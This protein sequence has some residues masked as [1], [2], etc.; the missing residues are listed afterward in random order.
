MMFIFEWFIIYTL[1]IFAMA[2]D[3]VIWIPDG[4]EWPEIKKSFYVVILPWF[5][6]KWYEY[7]FPKTK[8]AWSYCWHKR[9][10][11][12]IKHPRDI[13]PGVVSSFVLTILIKLIF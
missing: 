12:V 2:L 9:I 11:E 4:A 7:A 10:L 5:N 1:I 3:N 13:I 6:H 8:S